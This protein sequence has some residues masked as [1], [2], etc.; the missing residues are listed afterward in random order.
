MEYL[1]D[2]IPLPSPL[3][4][5]QGYS[6]STS[7]FS[8]TSLSTSQIS[9]A[10]TNSTITNLSGQDAPHSVSLPRSTPIIGS[11]SLPSQTSI[12]PCPSSSYSFVPSKVILPPVQTL[13]PSYNTLSPKKPRGGHSVKGKS[14]M[15][16][17]TRGK[18]PRG[19]RKGSRTLS[20]CS[21]HLI[22]SSQNLSSSQSPILP[23]GYPS[24][25]RALDL[26]TRPRVNSNF[27]QNPTLNPFFTNY[28]C[29]PKV[30]SPIVS[31][32][33]P[34]EYVFNMFSF[35]YT[36]D[37]FPGQDNPYWYLQ[38]NGE[39]HLLCPTLTFHL[40]WPRRLLAFY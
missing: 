2:P 40:I 26:S 3:F 12:N 31:F 7:T 37:F 21:P 22:S 23:W 13:P 30:F 25:V 4:L 6:S 33:E 8:S 35:I 38:L 39:T 24:V 17:S 19:Q 9:T 29:S 32:N 1:S 15:G 34:S 14:S 36:C 5:L 18:S 11:F 28:S 27:P 16:C 20:G 10:I